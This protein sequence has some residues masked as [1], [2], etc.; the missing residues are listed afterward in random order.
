MSADAWSI[1]GGPKRVM[2]DG[3]GVSISVYPGPT[4]PI[5]GGIDVSNLERGSQGE[6]LIYLY[7][8]KISLFNGSG[9]YSLD[10]PEAFAQRLIDYFTNPLSP[11]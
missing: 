3:P 9:F 6:L 10:V 4:K 1:S 5:E 11:S 7:P 8:P 2:I